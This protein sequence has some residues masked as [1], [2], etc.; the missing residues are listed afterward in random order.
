MS[1]F[2]IPF[3]ISI[4][5]LLAQAAA[6]KRQRRLVVV[7]VGGFSHNQRTAAP[8]AQ[9]ASGSGVVDD[10]A[11]Q[12]SP[13]YPTPEPKVESP[14]A[15]AEVGAVEAD[16]QTDANAVDSTESIK[17]D[18]TAT[19]TTGTESIAT[20]SAS[21]ESASTESTALESA[22][23][24]STAIESAP[25][26]S[27]ATESAPPESTAIGSAPIESIT[28]ESASIDSNESTVSKSASTESNELLARAASHEAALP[29]ESSQAA[30][31][32]AST[33][34]EDVELTTAAMPSMA[35]PGSG[36]SAA[37]SGAAHSASGAI[38]P[39]SGGPILPPT[40]RAALPDFEYYVSRK[41]GL[42][43]FLRVVIFLWF[44][45]LALYFFLTNAGITQTD[46]IPDPWVAQVTFATCALTG[47]TLI[48]SFRA[49][50]SYIFSTIE[51][52]FDWSI[53]QTLT[54]NWSAVKSTFES[55]RVFV[56][57]SIPHM[58][59]FFLYVQTMFYLLSQMS[60]KQDFQMP[61]MPIPM[62]LPM[63]Q[64]FSYN[65]L[66][67][68][69]L[70]FCGAGIFVTRNFRECLQRL[71]LVKPTAKQVGI[72]LGLVFMSF[73]YDYLWSLY[74]H[75]Q[76]LGLDTKLAGYNGGTFTAEGGFSASLILAFATALFAGVG[77]ETLIRGGLQ[78]MLGLVP[79]AILHGVLHAQ[80]QHAPIF[81]I[82]VAG[83]SIL[84]GIAKKYTNTTTT[85]IGHAG[86]NFLTTFLFSFNPPD[87]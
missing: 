37:D 77:E 57:T 74:T 85:I 13:I 75:G 72:G 78:P 32:P 39:V 34:K 5:G 86:F 4:F 82:Q 64:L 53:L 43:Y 50:L 67:L 51:S 3:V 46:L 2:L 12:P 27:I 45:G 71:G 62:P 61:G 48:R 6:G 83:W 42:E 56:P 49:G 87:M 22:P 29:K 38:P 66:G 26:E 35:A 28:T 10:S 7:P 73:L 9:Q 19:E 1:E 24:E 36:A 63:D 55:R 40:A 69:T 68:V 59:G 81:I 25:T 60:P 54:K 20:E 41:P 76:S 31:E 52:V 16:A 18:A 15:P 30:A 79:A 11:K 21:T 23:T 44:L 84:M 33:L 47:F 80:F 70:A 65:G 17:S 14:T 58:V 8:Q